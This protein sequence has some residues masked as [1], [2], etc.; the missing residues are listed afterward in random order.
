[1]EKYHRF[2]LG[3]IVWC[4][5]YPGVYKVIDIQNREIEKG[6]SYS[7]LLQ[8]ELVYSINNNPSF[9]K[10]LDELHCEKLDVGI[11]QQIEHLENVINKLKQYL[12]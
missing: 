7:D 11:K 5:L 2:K 12:N 3:E 8:I 10:R 6:R 9:T 1:M 4:A